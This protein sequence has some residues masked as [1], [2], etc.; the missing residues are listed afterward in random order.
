MAKFLKKLNK[1]PRKILISRTDRIGDF[2]L[3][4]PVF[5]CL[6]TNF[7]LEVTVLCNEL[8]LPLLD[9]NPFVDRKISIS[10]KTN[11]NEI[12]DEIRSYQFDTLLVM[13]ND[14]VIRRLIP[15]LR[16]IPTRIGPLSKPGMVFHYTHPVIQKRSKSIKNEAGYNLELLQIFNL[17]TTVSPTP[18]LHFLD[19]SSKLLKDRLGDR[20][21]LDQ[22]NKP[23]VVFHSGMSGSALNW[24]FE[25]YLQLLEKL[26]EEK[27][28]V[29]LTGSGESEIERN[30]I[31]FEKFHDKFSENLIN[32]T[33]LLNLQELAALIF[34]C[35]LYIGPST[36][37]THIASA[38]GTKVITFY[39]P[40]QVQSAQ[41]WGPFM[42]GATVF[43]PQVNCKEKYKC[44]GSRC[45]FYD[46]FESI[47]PENVMAQVRQSIPPKP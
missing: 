29:I 24:P 46:C 12:I 44:K 16:F 35:D 34:I 4:L 14:P 22:T 2:M 25:N 37:P 10:S 42:S 21:S 31:L 17:Q 33:G 18:K 3:T 41:R 32:I 27:H 43:T 45:E 13:V 28:I 15:K 38:T 23:K 11:D 40:I 20:I 19:N 39:P 36:G 5:E 7:D 30:R 6:K 8:V 1:I 9:D 26:L 47:S